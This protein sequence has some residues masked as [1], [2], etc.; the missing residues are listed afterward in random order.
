[1]T[2]P[3][4]K[5]AGMARSYDYTFA[6]MARSYEAGE[7]FAKTANAEPTRSLNPSITHHPNASA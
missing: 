1:M 4:W 3:R 5:F 2:L 7:T 6:G